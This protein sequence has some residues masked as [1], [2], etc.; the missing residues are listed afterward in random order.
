[1][2]PLSE[3]TIRSCFVNASRSEARK[4][5]LP[6][7][8]ETLPWQVLEYLGWRDP[9]MP[10][11][12]YLLRTD[13]NGRTRGLLLRAPESSRPAQ[14]AVL[15]EMCRD[16]THPNEVSMWVARRAGQ[17]GR[18]GN[19]LGTLICADFQCPA[20]VRVPPPKNAIN[21]EPSLVVERRISELGQRI[22]N[23]VAR[24]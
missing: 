6:A 9:K 22:D 3:K 19:T 10:Q 23:F 12:G 24:V 21:P 15:C 17:S 16:T 20:N 7:D 8:F 14:R 1:M 2:H 4:L 18:D 11:R 5:N 13:P